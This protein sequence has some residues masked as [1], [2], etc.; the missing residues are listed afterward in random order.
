MIDRDVFDVIKVAS[1]IAFIVIGITRRSHTNADQGCYL[2]QLYRYLRDC[3]FDLTAGY[4]GCDSPTGYGKS[5]L[6][7]AASAALSVR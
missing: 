2:I 6:P 1:A 4:M 5:A 3:F 7:A